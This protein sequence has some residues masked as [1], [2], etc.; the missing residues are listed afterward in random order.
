MNRNVKNKKSLWKQL[1]EN[2]YL[3]ILFLPTLIYFLLF[4]YVP[5]FGIVV[6]F[7]DY[8]IFKGVWASDWVGFKYF[9]TFFSSPDFFTLLR[10]TFLLGFYKL[11]FGFPAPIILA[12]LLNE[13]KNILFKRFVQSVSYMPHFLSNVVVASMIIM[14]LSP[15]HGLVNEIINLFGFESINFI[16]EKEWFRTIYVTSGIWQHLGWSTII[17]LAALANIDPQLYEAAEID[18]ANRWQKTWNVT[19]PSLIPAM[20]ILFLLDIGNIIELGFEKVFLLQTPVT[21]ETSDV[22]ATYVYRTGLVQGSFS[23]ATAIDLFTSVI[24][25]VFVVSGNYLARK[26]G[27][28]LW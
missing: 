27:N 20:V 2:K 22:L 23:Y 21:Y 25:I 24:G 9:T 5:M 13:L 26:S 28:S 7:K 18:G 12:L 19:I 15:N 14:F 17:Y 4:K 8:N 6:A 11:I 1:A 10:N 3:I 16:V